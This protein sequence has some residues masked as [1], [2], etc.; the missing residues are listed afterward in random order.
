M[1]DQ[2]KSIYDFMQENVLFGGV[3]QKY[4][5]DYCCGGK[6]PLYQAC[7]EAGVDINTVLGELKILAKEKE[8][9]KFSEMHL[10]ELISHVQETHHTYCRNTMPIIQ[11]VLKIVV[12]RHG[13]SHPELYK[14][15]SAFQDLSEILEM[16]LHKEDEVLFPWI[17]RLCE[18]EDTPPGRSNFT[19]RGSIE[20]PIRVMSAEH[21][22]IEEHIELMQKLTQNFTPPADACQKYKYS[23]GELN[24]FYNDLSMHAKKEETYLFPRAIELEKQYV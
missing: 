5:L 24:K 17:Q 23:F 7:M 6:K 14:I 22:A 19:F 15:F 4:G 2:A 9:E 16:H 8:D 3:F 11:D 21:E 20:H 18:L 10:T 13:E 12:T 1:L